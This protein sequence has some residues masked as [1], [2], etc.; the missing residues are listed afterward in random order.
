LNESLTIGNGNSG[1]ITFSGLTKTLTVADDITLSGGGKTL[2]MAENLT[3]GDG[4]NITITSTGQPNTLT[5]AESL[6]IGDGYNVTITAE[7]SATAIVMDNV[8]FEVENTNGTQRDIKITSAKAGNTTLTFNEDLTIG[9][10]SNITITAEDNNASVVLDNA[11]FEIENTNGTQRDMKLAFGSDANATLTITGTSGAINQDVSTTATPTFNGL[12]T[13][14]HITT[15]NQ[16]TNIS[17]IDNNAS[18]LIVKEGNNSYLTFKTTNSKENVNF[19]KDMLLDTGKFMYFNGLGD[20]ADDYRIGLASYTGDNTNVAVDYRFEIQRYDNTAGGWLTQYSVGDKG[21]LQETGDS[22]AYAVLH[23]SGDGTYVMFIEPDLGDNYGGNL[24]IRTNTPGNTNAQI[25]NGSQGLRSTIQTSFSGG[26]GNTISGANN[27]YSNNGET[28]NGGIVEV[29]GNVMMEGA[30]SDSVYSGGALVLGKEGIENSYKFRVINEA[31]H[32]NTSKTISKFKIEKY[33]SDSSSWVENCCYEVDVTSAA[34][35]DAGSYSTFTEGSKFSAAVTTSVKDFN[36]GVSN[37]GYGLFVDAD[38]GPSDLGSFSIRRNNPETPLDVSGDMSISHGKIFLNPS[39]TNMTL[40]VVNG[41]LQVRNSGGTGILFGSGETLGNTS[42]AVIS[43]SYNDITIETSDFELKDTTGNTPL[44][45][46]DYSESK[47]GFRNKQPTS[48]FDINGYLHI[49][50][51][52]PVIY[53]GSTQNNS[54]VDEDYSWRMKFENNTFKIEA[55]FTSS[56]W[57]SVTE[58]MPDE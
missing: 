46:V 19:N 48:E 2:T 30:T 51:S 50:R 43:P 56:G 6:T 3:I 25:T 58:F 8:N 57:A 5:M 37:N 36:V 40:E 14:G 45:T 7:D 18:A 52:T 24:G 10:G 55:N 23:A 21:F 39:N 44:L 9:D 13:T 4:T 49:N 42:N 31:S 26:L 38:G 35:N 34:P 17:I 27:T 54:G 29:V 41:Q 11:N 20:N 15:S 22:N 53:F 32:T 1:T 33:S 28:W 47:I 12:T 16:A